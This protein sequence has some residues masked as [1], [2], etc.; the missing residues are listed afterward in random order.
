[1]LSLLHMV[2]MTCDAPNFLKQFKPRLSEQRRASPE[3]GDGFIVQIL[4]MN[5]E[6]GRRRH[7]SGT[8]R[9]QL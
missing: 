9:H 5:N 6:S 3:E 2:G 7:M 8:K 4:D 1:L